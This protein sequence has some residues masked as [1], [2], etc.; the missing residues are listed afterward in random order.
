M[1]YH[2]L[3][4]PLDNLTHIWTGN[5]SLQ[6]LYF[7]FSYALPGSQVEWIIMRQQRIP[8]S[9]WGTS[10]Q[11]FLMLTAITPNISNVNRCILLQ[12]I[13]Q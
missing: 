9:D 7:Y 13:V 3:H 1:L 2:E 10:M 5:L 6:L 11:H 4:S 8:E 12:N